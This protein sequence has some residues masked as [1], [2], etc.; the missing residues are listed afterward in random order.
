MTLA[1]HHASDAG[2]VIRVLIV[3]DSAIVRGLSARWLA[4]EE[5]IEVAAVAVDGLDGVRKAR[6]LQPD[7][8]VLDVEMPRLDGLGALPELV[9]TC[10]NAKIL[11][12]STLTVR[13]AEI[14]LDALSKGAADFLPKPE[15]GRI[16]GAEE[17]RAE[18]TRKIRALGRRTA[19]ARVAHGRAG[20]K[21]DVPLARG[22][23]RAA[24]AGSLN[25]LSQ[26]LTLRPYQCK[27][28]QALVIGA[29]T[30][31]PQALR[32]FFE[33][34]STPVPAP[35]FIVQHMPATFTSILAG[36][37]SRLPGIS[38]IEARDG[39]PVRA[40]EIVIAPGG[41]HLTI[42]VRQGVATTHLD[43]RPPV[44][45]C[46]PAVD[47]MFESAAAGFTSG[48]LSV[49]LT[50]MG[51]DGA[52]G[53]R[54]IVNAGGDVIAQDEASSVVWGMPGAVARA[55]LAAAIGPVEQLTDIVNQRLR[56]RGR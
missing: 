5:G 43:Q 41:K 46:R 54:A 52:D 48:V 11:M 56:G 39:A 36:H 18:L 8:I 23:G 51:S 29:S 6:D 4:E 40:G 50:G 19:G 14:T 49:V 35:V 16:S 13:N 3:D 33:R 20:R 32:A 12:A 44:H 55:G 22:V 34:L 27:Q 15:T 31:G 42:R 28:P 38:C 30:G 21:V 45:F 9:K 17:Y 53:A 2:H 37:L 24:G 26:P 47:P 25:T 7:V 1:P 10:P